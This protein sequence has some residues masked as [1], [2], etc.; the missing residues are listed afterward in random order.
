[1]ERK[2]NYALCIKRL[3]R[4]SLLLLCATGCLSKSRQN[5]FDSTG[6]QRQAQ[7]DERTGQAMEVRL[8]PAASDSSG[9]LTFKARLFLTR[10]L[11]ADAPGTVRSLQYNV[12]S[13][14]CIVAAGDTLWPNYVMPIANGQQLQPEYLAEFSREAV[15]KASVF[16]FSTHQKGALGMGEL[17]VPFL[18]K[19]I[20]ILNPS[21][22]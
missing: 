16:H 15:Q 14:F 4:W 11:F 2:N 3:K 12:D 22:N 13:L 19:D 10:N 17:Q 1:M 18:K 20:A 6:M 9:G 7:R 5:L 21:T 8:F